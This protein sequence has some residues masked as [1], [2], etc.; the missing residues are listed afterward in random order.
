MVYFDAWTQIGP[1]PN[2]HPRHPWRLE[3]LLK[4]M[5][6]CSISAALVSWSMTIQWIR[7]LLRQMVLNIPE[8][9]LD[10]KKMVSLLL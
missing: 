8:N 9:H 7:A 6:Y 1:F 2:K 5:H 10:F 3:D 4:E